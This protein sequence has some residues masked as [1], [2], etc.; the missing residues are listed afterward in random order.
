RPADRKQGPGEAEGRVGQAQAGNGG[1]AGLIALWIR[2]Q[3]SEMIFTRSPVDSVAPGPSALR[4]RKSST[5]RS[6]PTICAAKVATFCPGPTVRTR[7]LRGFSA[8]FSAS[9]MTWKLP[10]TERAVS[11]S[12]LLLTGAAVN[13]R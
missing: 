1:N 2:H 8:A 5:L 10:L 11:S 9:L 7:I 4:S 12:A 6:T 13:R 3:R